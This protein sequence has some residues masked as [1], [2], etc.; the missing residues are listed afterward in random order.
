MFTLKEKEQK[1]RGE[2]RGGKGSGGSASLFY[3]VFSLLNC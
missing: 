2:Q 3:L 1:K